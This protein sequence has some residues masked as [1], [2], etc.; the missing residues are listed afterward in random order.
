MTKIIALCVAVLLI[1][2]DSFAK[3]PVSKGKTKRFSYEGHLFFNATNS[4][5]RG[6]K[7]LLNQQL[8]N[9]KLGSELL[10]NDW[11]KMKGLLIL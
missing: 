8:S 5:V 10:L 4:A 1:S 9:V 7:Y 6:E 11:S 3:D 2:F